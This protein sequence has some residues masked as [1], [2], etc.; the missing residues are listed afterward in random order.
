MGETQVWTLSN[1]II[2]HWLSIVR[3]IA[4][5]IQ[6]QSAWTIKPQTLIDLRIECYMYN[7]F[8]CGNNL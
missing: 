7:G 6:S 8:E 1:L 3:I 4:L 2:S 5:H